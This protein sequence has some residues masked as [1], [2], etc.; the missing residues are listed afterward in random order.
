MRIVIS[1]V[2]YKVS[3]QNLCRKVSSKSKEILL[4]FSFCGGIDIAA[5]V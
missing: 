4:V 3:E 2:Y 1:K 5:E